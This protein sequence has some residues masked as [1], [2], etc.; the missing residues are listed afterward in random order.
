MTDSRSLRVCLQKL[1]EIHVLCAGDLMLDRFV[2]G[3]VSRISPEAPVPVLSIEREVSMLGGAGNVVR[4][5]CAL[6]CAVTVAAV[7]GDDEVGEEVRRLLSDLP[8]CRPS[9][10]IESG[11]RTPVKQRFLSHG[12]Q[13]LRVDQESTDPISESTMAA[14]LRDFTAAVPQ[15]DVVVLSDYNKGL[16][17]GSNAQRFIAAAVECGKPVIV[18]PKGRNFKRYRSVTVL[19]PNLKELAEATSVPAD[20]ATGLEQAARRALRDSEASWLVVTRGAEGMSLFSA[21][22]CRRDFPSMAR[23]VFDVSGAGD[24]VAA[25]LAAALGAGTSVE[26]AVSLANLAAG[27]VVAKVGTAVVTRQELEAE[28]DYGDLSRE[29]AGCTA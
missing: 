18:D 28:V 9:I 3:D 26:E 27:L 16:L 2:Y 5:L 23:E 1:R 10:A 24:T 29:T 11:R 25:T 20:S 8:N 4:N 21:D 13:L 14:I 17:S 19:K 15:C 22:G 7:A 12:Q 6:G